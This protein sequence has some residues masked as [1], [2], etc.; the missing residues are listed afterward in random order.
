MAQST[1]FT[2]A[3]A[4]RDYVQTFAPDL[5]AR[6]FYGFRT[7]QVVT[8]HD[9]VKGKLTLTELQLGT[10]VRRWNKTFNPVAGTLVFEPRHLDV[11]AARAEMSIVPQEF[12]SSYLGYARQSSF[13]Q[14]EPLPFEGF[15]MMK[16]AEKMMMEVEDAVWRGEDNGGST[17]T[18]PLIDIMDGFLT[19]IADDQAG[20][21][22]LNATTTP[23]G[24]VT[25][26]NVVKLIE[27]M[28]QTLD[29][30]Y[31]E[32]PVGIFVSPAIWHLYQVAYREE[33]GKYTGLDLG[34]GRMKLDFANATLIR[35]PGMGS[36]ERI[37]ITPVDNLHIGYDGLIGENMNFEKDHRALDYWHDFKIG[38]QIGILDPA[39]M[40]IN[41]LA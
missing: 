17:A 40:A 6:A 12:E 1:D 29:P 4:F 18:D 14:V 41:D 26:T 39:I 2:S 33:Y 13:N 38:C 28:H 7:A 21:S 19:L 31:Q 22:V 32:M 27:D 11:S 3:E 25:V 35:T 36:S 37:V 16:W 20:A 30:I 8:T 9:N 10:L 5:I 15:I 34:E 23:G 24:S